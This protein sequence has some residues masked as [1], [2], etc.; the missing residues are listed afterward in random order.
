MFFNITSIIVTV[1]WNCP[2]WSLCSAFTMFATSSTALVV[3]SGTT[4]L[5]WRRHLCNLFSR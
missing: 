5:N 1:A 2:V 3:L 4:S